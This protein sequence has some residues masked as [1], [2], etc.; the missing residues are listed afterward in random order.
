MRNV[1]RIAAL[2]AAIA[3]VGLV[4]PA[5]AKPKHNHGDQHQAYAGHSRGHHEY[6]HAYRH[7]RGPGYGYSGSSMAPGWQGWYGGER[8]FGWSRGMKRGWH[9]HHTPPGLYGQYYR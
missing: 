6:R 9:G 7:Y 3:A 4:S 2:T 1:F 8:P 5:D